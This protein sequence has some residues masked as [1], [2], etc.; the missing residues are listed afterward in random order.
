MSPCNV[1]RRQKNI[2]RPLMG[3]RPLLCGLLGPSVLE[4]RDTI[5]K[6]P[7]ALKTNWPNLPACHAGHLADHRTPVGSVRLIMYSTY[8]RK[9]YYSSRDFL[10]CAIFHMPGDPCQH[11]PE[12]SIPYFSASAIHPQPSCAQVLRLNFR[13]DS[14]SNRSS[15]H[16]HVYFWSS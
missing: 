13:V 15:P 12:V 4:K 6:P 8:Y 3:Y 7:G 9:L 10:S 11:I 14:T 1:A 16:E 2:G 5:R